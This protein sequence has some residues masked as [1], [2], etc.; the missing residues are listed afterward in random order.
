I[1]ALVAFTIILT[2][3]RLI[4]GWVSLQTVYFP[5]LLIVSVG[6]A[7]RGIVGTVEGYFRI[8]GRFDQAAK[9]YSISLLT[10]L[11]LLVVVGLLVPTLPAVSWATAGADLLYF[12][13]MGGTL[14]FVLR[15]SGLG[16]VGAELRLIKDIRQPLTTFLLSTNLIYSV[17][18]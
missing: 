7:T 11:I 8:S 10:R 3:G 17:R 2:L 1:V 5:A 12:A 13:L 18:T 9:L 16:Y 14:L 15:R 6:F 4:L